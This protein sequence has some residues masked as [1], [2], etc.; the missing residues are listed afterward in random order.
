MKNS[1]SYNSAQTH[2]TYM[3]G[4]EVETT[5]AVSVKNG[6][7]TKMV[8]KK[9]NGKKTSKTMKLKPSE[10]KNI[11]ERK[12]MPKLFFPCLNHCNRSLSKGK[13]LRL[14]N[15]KTL[16]FKKKGTKKYSK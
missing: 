6:K 13:S 15:N 14:K 12:F 10:I 2:Y 8:V 16:R 7:G 9:E 1:F 4:K 11:Q 3:N 5:E